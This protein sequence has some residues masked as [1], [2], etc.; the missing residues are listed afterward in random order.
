MKAVY[1]PKNEPMRIAA[2]MSGKGSNLRKILEMQKKLAKECPFRVALVFSDVKDEEKC[3]AKR[4]AK[5]YGIAYYCN[6]IKEHYESRGHKD[7]KDMKVRKEYDR[8]TAK[9][10][11]SEKIDAVA[12]CG[13]NS[14]TTG[15]IFN[16]F[17]TV[18]VHPADLRILDRNGR[19]LYA[20]CE[21]AGCIRKVIESEGKETRAT[22][23]LVTKEV[24]GGPIIMVS[25]PVKIDGNLSDEQNLERLKEQGDWKAYPET[26]R[27]LAEGRYWTDENGIV[28]DVFE[29]KCLLREGMRKLRE[30]LSDNDV[31]EKS[32]AIN[33]RLLHLEEYAKAK[34][35]M[36]YVGINKEVKTEEAIK[37]ALNAKKNV[38]V[39]VTDL[40]K[41]R[42]T[43][44][45]LSSLSSLKPGAY[46]ILEPS[47]GKEVDEKEIELVI[48][49]GL[50]FDSEGNRVG[51]GLGFYDRFLRNSGA[52]KIALAY[53][54][55]IVDRVLATGNDVPMDL[56]I[57]EKQVIRRGV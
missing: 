46:G 24:D 25:E 50:A 31:K 47:G 49:P 4:I 13:Y 16:N 42:I 52:K 3:N 26:I 37:A 21:G 9:I 20:G 51:Y 2:F 10:L 23:H 22:T 43:P 1:T 8:E 17:L 41:G 15:E 38:A 6:D 28:V 44:V 30:K 29:E 12:M 11:K 18:N 45:K 40:E 53:E 14:I 33:K 19:K 32:S 34:T 55:Q 39:P 35:L 56:I 54:M 57:T 27:R 36:F 48:V 5:E 7:R